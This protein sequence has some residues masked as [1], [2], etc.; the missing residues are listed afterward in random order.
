MAKP[1]LKTLTQLFRESYQA[2][3]RNLSLFV[4][5]NVVTILGTA[6]NIGLDIRDKTHGSDW[7][8]VL[9]HGFTGSGDYPH[10]HGG[11]SVFFILVGLILGLIGVFLSFKAAQRKV[12]SFDEVWEIFKAKWWKVILV[13]II[14]ILFILGGLVA[15]VLP[16]LYLIAR[17]S[18]APYV[19]IDQD[20]DVTDAIRKSWEMSKNHAWT[21]FVTVFFGLVLSL[22]S[23]IPVVGK[24]ISL[25]LVIAYSVALPIRYFELK[26]LK[27]DG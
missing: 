4:F 26:N 21:I 16:G 17:L 8:Q 5:V 9:G 23:F 7:G 6:W 24:L 18:L 11:L 13:E 22:P 10:V 12:V 15:L 3:K 27:E 20:G 1:Q 2:V 14:I 25:I 19:A